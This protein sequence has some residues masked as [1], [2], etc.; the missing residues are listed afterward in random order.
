MKFF[1]NSSGIKFWIEKVGEKIWVHFKGRTFAVDNKQE[2]L[3]HKK[4]SDVQKKSNLV[5]PVPGR[6]LSIKVKE[7]DSVQKGDSLIVIESMKIEHTLTAFQ[8]GRIKSILVQ[9]G[10]S[11][12][13]NEKLLIFE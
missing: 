2:P 6:V 8:S 12:E 1:K 9:K 5:S 4:T 13:S 7:G 11:V 3:V 10:Q